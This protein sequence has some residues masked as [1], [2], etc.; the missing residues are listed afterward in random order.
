MPSFKPKRLVLRGAVSNI[1]KSPIQSEFVKREN[2]FQRG[3]KALEG[4]LTSWLNEEI[5]PHDHFG[6]GTFGDEFNLAFGSARIG[7]LKFVQSTDFLEV[8][9]RLSYEVDAGKIGVREDCQLYSDLGVRN[10]LVRLLLNFHPLLVLLAVEAI[11]GMRF[12]LN[13]RHYV[14]NPDMQEHVISVGTSLILNL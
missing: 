8:T 6:G 11:D 9:S 14:V 13:A 4:L 5:V 12:K 2:V 1:P 7:V 10:E 3:N